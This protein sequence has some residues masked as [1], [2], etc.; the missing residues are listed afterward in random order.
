[1]A[2]K[3]SFST[4]V[5]FKTNF[6]LIPSNENQKPE[7]TLLFPGK[8]EVIF[9]FLWQGA[10]YL[11]SIF[12][13]NFT[14]NCLNEGVWK[15]CFLISFSGFTNIKKL[16]FIKTSKSTFF[17]LFFFPKP[18]LPKPQRDFKRRRVNCEDLNKEL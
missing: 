8:Q 9:H 16:F 3:I 17:A 13:W 1:M 14:S 4:K 7:Q 15:D 18:E 5:F 6:I 12:A 10:R 11:A 2:C